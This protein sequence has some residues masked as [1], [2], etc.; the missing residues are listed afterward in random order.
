VAICG[1][2]AA[3][4]LVVLDAELDQPRVHQRIRTGIECVGA[5][6]ERID[7]RRGIFGRSDFRVVG[8]IAKPGLCPL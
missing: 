5:P 7:R 4:N 1:A 3:S 6:L 2:R 8:V